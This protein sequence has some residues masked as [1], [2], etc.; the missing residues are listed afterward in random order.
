MALLNLKKN[1]K[2]VYQNSTL[3]T[4]KKIYW[5]VFECLV[6]LIQPYP[7]LTDV[8]FITK[9]AFRNIKFLYP[10]N[11]LLAMG[12][13]F[14]TYIILRGAL[15]LTPYLSNRCNSPFIQQTDSAKCTGVE[16][17]SPSH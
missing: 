10:L 17:T 8:F 11:N 9:N 12:S 1:R 4:T 14:R 5:L 2:E 6:I 3:F 7:F 15:L 16:L 13:L